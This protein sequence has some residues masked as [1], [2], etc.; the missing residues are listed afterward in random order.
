MR[1]WPGLCPG[2]R[3]GSSRHSLRH[4]CQLGR[5]HPF[6]YLTPF[7]ASI[8]PPSA[9]SFGGHCPPNIFFYNSTCRHQT[10]ATIQCHAIEKYVTADEQTTAEEHHWIM[11]HKPFISASSNTQ[12]L[13]LINLHFTLIG[14][15]TTTTTTTTRL[16]ASTSTYSLT[17]RV[18]VTTPHSTDEM[19]R[20]TQ[21][22]R[23][24]YR[25]W[26]E[27]SPACVV[28]MCGRPADYRQALPRISIVLP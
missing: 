4:L 28:C 26:G 8:L 5:G 9:N 23:Q 3:W 21:Q 1:F 10:I 7:G 15:S 19:E 22:A 16:H 14:L 12:H 18:R 13:T 11:N 2:P 24:F 20:H 6:P 17:F 25:R 27:S